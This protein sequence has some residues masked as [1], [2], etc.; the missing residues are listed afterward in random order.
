VNNESKQINEWASWRRI[1]DRIEA[2]PPIT[3]IEEGIARISGGPAVRVVAR[4]RLDA[5]AAWAVVGERAAGERA[6]LVVVAQTS[7][8]SAR[9]I[10][11]EHEIGVVDGA[12]AARI[13]LPGLIVHIEPVPGASRSSDRAARQARLAGRS[14]LIGQALLLWSDE[15]WQVQGLAQRCGVSKALVSTLLRRLEEDGIVTSHGAGPNKLRRL[16]RP[17]ALLDLLAEEHQDRGVESIAGY[18]FSQ[19]PAQLAGSV[20]HALG[21]ENVRYA[22]TGFAASELIAPLV[23]SVPEVAVWVGGARPLREM[24]TDVGGEPV[25]V[26]ANL[27]MRRARDD[28]P[29][30]FAVERDGVMLANPVRIYL[31]L[32][33]DPRRGAEQAEHVRREVLGL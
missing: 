32:V 30:A 25:D 33:G 16:E 1:W 29:L 19:S 6:P 11:A 26:G 12:G 27:I 3:P 5:A 4:A 7:T 2:L 15:T 18:R 8:A 21:R 31:D 24:L 17:A 10:L 22:L 28:G 20:A 23:T 14:S 9:R 13:A